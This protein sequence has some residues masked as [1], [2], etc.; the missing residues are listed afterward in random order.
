MV[1]PEHLFIAIFQEPIL[2]QTRQN[3]HTLFE[4][5]DLS[6]NTIILRSAIDNPTALSKSLGLSGESD[7]PNNIG[8]VFTLNGSYYGYHAQTLWDWLIKARGKVIG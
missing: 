1:A 6:D 3:I 5:Y 8:V 7:P 2:S 4:A